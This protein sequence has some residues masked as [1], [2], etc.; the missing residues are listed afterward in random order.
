MESPDISK[1]QGQV[2]GDAW[3]TWSPG[4]STWWSLIYLKPR[5]KYLPSEAAVSKAQWQVPGEAWNI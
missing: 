1:V 3:Y 2:P 4:T 5:D